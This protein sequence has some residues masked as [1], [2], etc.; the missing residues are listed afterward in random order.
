M[1]SSS[2]AAREYVSRSESFVRH[3]RIRSFRLCGV[4]AERAMTSGIVVGNRVRPQAAA[5]DVE[6]PATLPAGSGTQN[7]YGFFPRGVGE[8]GGSREET[9][10][11]F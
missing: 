6:I 1:D 8:E 11:C 9:G 10:L 7:G 5:T 4:E 2:D 3:E